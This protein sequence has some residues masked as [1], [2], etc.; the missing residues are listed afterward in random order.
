MSAER[1][2]GIPDLEYISRIAQETTLVNGFHIPTLIVVGG[3]RLEI[4]QIPFDNVQAEARHSLMK[5][6][7]MDMATQKRLGELKRLFLVTE[8]WL[9]RPEEPDKEYVPPSQDPNRVE[10]L[11]IA[12]LDVNSGQ[13]E[14]DIFEMR[15]RSDGDLAE[16]ISIELGGDEGKTRAYLLEKF[17]EGY[18]STRAYQKRRTSQNG[19]Q[20]S[21]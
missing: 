10:A 14:M 21:R 3:R 13:A 20:K 9:G 5:V 1:K 4:I 19:G 8:G 7:G 16:L 6:I 18:Q 17:A 12:M 2:R 11:I 15:R